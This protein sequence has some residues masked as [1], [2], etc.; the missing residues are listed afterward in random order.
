M[1]TSTVHPTPECSSTTVVASN[2]S[3]SSEHPRS[4]PVTLKL[5]REKEEEGEGRREGEGRND[6]KDSRKKSVSWTNETVDNEGLGRKSSK[7]CC[8]YVKPTS[9]RVKDGDGGCHSS[10]SED[11]T[12]DGECDHCVGHTPKSH[13]SGPQSDAGGDTADS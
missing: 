2:Q 1:A 3:A 7:C 13:S 4:P 5:R 6:S 11:D 9:K 12:D 10:D 8:I